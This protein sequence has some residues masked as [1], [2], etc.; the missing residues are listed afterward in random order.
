MSEI[1][2]DKLTGVGTAGSIVVT[3][4]GNSTT[5]NIQ[6]GLTKAWANY[7]LAG[8]HSFRDS[9][10]MSSITDNAFGK[11]TLALVNSFTSVNYAS[12]GIGIKASDGTAYSTSVTVGNVKTS[13]S[14]KLYHMYTTAF[15]DMPDASFIAHGDL[16]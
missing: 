3:G 13:G 6:Q 8:T 15:Y 1:K 11:S 12:S 9:F 5:T 14:I 7:E 16:A 2:T 10:N 4:E